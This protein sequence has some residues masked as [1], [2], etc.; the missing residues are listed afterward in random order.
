M[1]VM[2]KIKCANRSNEEE[3]EILKIVLSAID[4]SNQFLFIET[5]LQP[6]INRLFLDEMDVVIIH[7]PI[8]I[9]D[10]AVISLNNYLNG[11][12]GLIWFQGNSM[13]V[14]ESSKL[15]NSLGFPKIKSL[16][17]S[18]NQSSFFNIDYDNS[19]S[20]L[21]SDLKLKKIYNELPQIFSYLKKD[22]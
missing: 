11:G 10:D 12:G 22:L 3:L 15:S 2:E 14:D 1:P 21:L 4:P 18:G 5:R 19:N 7:N 16:V 13:D 6:N 9:S 20:A 8:S 17:S